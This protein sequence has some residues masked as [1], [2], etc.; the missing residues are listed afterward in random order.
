MYTFSSKQKEGT[1]VA[2][3]SHTTGRLADLGDMGEWIIA[4]CAC[5]LVTVCQQIHWDIRSSGGELQLWSSMCTCP[6]S[7]G[8]HTVTY[9][10][11]SGKHLWNDVA[12]FLKNQNTQILVKNFI[13]FLLHV[14]FIHSTCPLWHGLEER[15]VEA[16]RERSILLSGISGDEWYN[17]IWRLF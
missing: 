1:E 16:Q 12:Q 7:Q 10:E 8:F 3:S 4:N 6:D 2:C 11:V 9:I 14:P 15:G 17:E 5:N 13:I